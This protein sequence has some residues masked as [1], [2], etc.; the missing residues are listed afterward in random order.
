M[1]NINREG[2]AHLCQQV[3]AKVGS[4]DEE[5]LLRGL[6]V[7]LR[8]E[9]GFDDPRDG[10]LPSGYTPKEALW[11][12]IHHLF[13]HTFRKLPYFDLTQTINKELLSKT[14]IEP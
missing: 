7:P 10:T 11:N 5:D 12:N 13:D 6:L 3:R 14:D 2:F 9:L 4:D 8:I 1:I